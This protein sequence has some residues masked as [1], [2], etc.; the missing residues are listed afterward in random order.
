MN[1]GAPIAVL[2]L[3]IDHNFMQRKRR[4]EKE[5][6]GAHGVLTII[7]DHHAKP[8]FNVENFQTLM[9]VMVAHGISKKATE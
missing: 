1:N 2:S 6:A 9:P 5:P 8:L 4:E 3:L 7:H